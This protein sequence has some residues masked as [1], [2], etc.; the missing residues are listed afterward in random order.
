MPRPRWTGRAH[1]ETLSA[2]AV[3]SFRAPIRRRASNGSGQK[4][5]KTAPSRADRDPA[6]GDRLPAGGRPRRP[7][8]GRPVPGC[9]HI[10]ETAAN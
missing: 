4:I 3:A 8:A 10:N 7:G 5:S 1:R 9:G 6:V 2:Q